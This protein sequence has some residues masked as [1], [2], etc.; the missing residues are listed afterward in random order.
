MNKQSVESSKSFTPEEFTY[1]MKALKGVSQA[2]YDY[3]ESKNSYVQSMCKF[4]PALRNHHIT[5][6]LS[7]SFNGWGSKARHLPM[8][9]LVDKIRIQIIEKINLRSN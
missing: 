3:L 6:N 1:H 8:M 4:C 2:A 5:N 7:E 9:D